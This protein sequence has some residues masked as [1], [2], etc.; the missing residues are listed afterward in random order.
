MKLVVTERTSSEPSSDSIKF[1]SMERESDNK[2]C[3]R[4]SQTPDNQKTTGNVPLSKDGGTFRQGIEEKRL[5]K[6]FRQIE[7]SRRTLPFLNMCITFHFITYSTSTK[8]EVTRCLCESR[9]NL[10]LQRRVR[11]RSL[12]NEM[13]ADA[14]MLFISEQV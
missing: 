3:Q 6:I 11:P 8:Y 1:C 9:Y 4:P 5:F 14:E 10:D 7:G 2:A 12:L 13:P